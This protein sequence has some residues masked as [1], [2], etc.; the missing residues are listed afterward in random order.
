MGR[1]RIASCQINTRVGDLDHNVERILDALRAGRGGRVRPGR[2]PR[3]GHHRLP[4]RGPAAEARLRRR[5]PAS[6]SSGWRRPPDAAWPWSASS[7]RAATS[8]TRRRSAPTARCAGVYRK[9]ELPNYAVFDEM[10]YFARRPGARDSSTSSAASASA[11][12]S[13][14]TR[15]TRPGP[16]AD[17]ADSGAELIVNLNASPY[18]EGKQ[19]RRERHAGDPGGRRVV[20]ARLRQPG[21]R[22]GRA[23][24]RRRL[25]GVRRRRR[26]ARP[27]AAV[28]RG[29]A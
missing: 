22:P 9:R 10:R 4:A 19:A 27:L 24:L 20:R 5:Q 15:G 25:D 6:R 29:R 12:R 21:R 11:S 26:A 13:A 1:L 2:V 3:A 18:A 14:R 17:Q 8:A 16:I 23:G 7:T 28:R